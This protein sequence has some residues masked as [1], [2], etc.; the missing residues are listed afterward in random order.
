MFYFQSLDVI[1]DYDDN[2]ESLKANIDYCQENIAECQSSIVQMEEAKV[3]SVLFYFIV[4]FYALLTWFMHVKIG[5]SNTFF[6]HLCARI[7]KIGVFL[8]II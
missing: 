5:F 4:Y 7:I 3:R 8:M 1:Q 6:T 2:I